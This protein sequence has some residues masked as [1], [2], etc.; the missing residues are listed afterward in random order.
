MPGYR[1]ARNVSVPYAHKEDKETLVP[2]RAVGGENGS[3]SECIRLTFRTA[4]VKSQ[5]HYRLP[6]LS[7]IR[8]LDPDLYK[9]VFNFSD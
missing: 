2:S 9:W 4:I 6:I 7:K 1:E 3:Y 5:F 8:H